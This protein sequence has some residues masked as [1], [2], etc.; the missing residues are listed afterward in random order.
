MK[1]P[2]FAFTLLIIACL[3]ARAELKWDQTSVELHPAATDKQAVGHFKYQNT[4]KTPVHFKSVHPSCGCT[5][6]QTQKEIVQAGEKGEI[7]ATFN[8]GD[9]TGTQVKTVT[10]ETDEA[11]NQ[12]TV[13]TLKAI[14]PQ[15]LEINPTFVFWKQGDKPDPKQISVKVGKDF[16]V[17]HI[18]VTSSSPDF[19][20]KVEDTGKGEFKIDVTPQDTNKPVA[21]MLTIQSEDSPKTFYATARITGAPLAPPM[22]PPG[23]TAPARPTAPTSQ[24]H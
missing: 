24:T 12:K 19:Q 2:I 13:L 3:S 21:S 15:Q 20:A 11:A 1:T 16:T 10:V 8:I 5:T 4:G 22:A 7:T 14:I 9:R 23:A 18:K 6:A 17:K